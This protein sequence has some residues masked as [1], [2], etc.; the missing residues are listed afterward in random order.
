VTAADP[1]TSPPRSA[2]ARTEDDPH[3]DR[4]ADDSGVMAAGVDLLLAADEFAARRSTLRDFD[5]RTI[6]SPT[7][8]SV[9]L[10]RELPTAAWAGVLALI[11]IGLVNLHLADFRFLSPARLALP[12]ALSL[13][14]TI[15][16]AAHLSGVAAR[17]LIQPLPGSRRH[18]IHVV[19]VV[20]AA[21]VLWFG[22]SLDELW[23]TTTA[24]MAS[25]AAV[26]PLRWAMLVLVTLA[27]MAH[28]QPTVT[29]RSRLEARLSEAYGDLTDAR[30]RYLDLRCEAP[31]PGERDPYLERAEHLLT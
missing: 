26:V 1:R 12:L 14:V 25:S 11:A 17:R 6:E 21:A 18:L 10:D 27:S 13:T 15:V 8:G 24:S 7:G 20:V 3:P 31:R 19:L 5:H 28:E 22:T 16:L 30:Q 23:F 2:H 29:A 4:P 9:W